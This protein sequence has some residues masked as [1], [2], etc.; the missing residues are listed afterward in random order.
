[1]TA[2]EHL[3]R[4]RTTSAY[5]RLD[6]NERTTLENGLRS[7]IDGAGGSYAYTEYATLVTARARS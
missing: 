6:A 5:L 3:T 2:E 7:V 4:I 1:V